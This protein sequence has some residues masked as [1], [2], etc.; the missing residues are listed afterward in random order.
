MIRSRSMAA[1]HVGTAIG[2]LVIFAPVV[3]N[4][5]ILHVPAEYST[6]Q[7][8]VDASSSGDTVLVAPGEYVGDV[9]M[10]GKLIT[11][12]SSDGATKTTIKAMEH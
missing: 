7:A 4:G 11:L 3:A 12:R 8:A 6:I 9:D 10:G 5:L 1:S 2:A